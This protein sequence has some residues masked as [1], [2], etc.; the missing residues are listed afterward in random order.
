MQ[1]HAVGLAL[2]VAELAI[3]VRLHLLVG[4]RQHLPDELEAHQGVVALSHLLLELHWHLDSSRSAWRHHQD[5]P[6]GRR[7]QLHIL[8]QNISVQFLFLNS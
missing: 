7:L 6:P 5:L 3:I 8:L 1:E 2:L 4:D